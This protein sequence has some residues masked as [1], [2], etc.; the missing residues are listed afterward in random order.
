V[1][2]PPP[3]RSRRAVFPHRALQAD[4]LPPC[5]LGFHSRL[6]RV[7]A[8]DAARP[9]DLQVAKPLDQTGPRVAP[10]RA[11]AIQ[12]RAQDP[13]GRAAERLPA[14]G[15]AVHAIIAVVTPPCDVQV[16]AHV[17]DPAATRFPA[18][19]GAPRARVPPCL[20]RR[21]ALQ[22][23]LATAIRP[24]ATR[25]AQ[26][27]EPGAATG[28]PVT[29]RHHPRLGHGHLQPTRAEPWPQRLRAAVGRCLIVKRGHTISRVPDQAGLAAT[30]GLDHVLTP[31]VEGIVQRSVGQEG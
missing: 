13:P 10:P 6:T 11:A 29:P 31:Q 2:R 18:P 23:G 19:G 24:P 28:V 16:P 1:T 7:R 27:V 21:T 5:G 15:V 30:A 20:A 8:P 12:P 4:S 26:N 22:R 9:C 14:G 25:T 3:H 17:P